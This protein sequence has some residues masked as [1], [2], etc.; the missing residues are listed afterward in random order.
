MLFKN[1]KINKFYGLNLKPIS[2]KNVTIDYFDYFHKNKNI[3]KY[4]HF[5]T[6]LF[7]G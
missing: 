5:D 6:E 2:S 4:K 7:E 1:I 3:N